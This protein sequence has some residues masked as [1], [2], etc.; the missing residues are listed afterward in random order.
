MI[1][2]IIFYV[3]VRGALKREDDYR[4]EQRCGPQSLIIYCN[5]ILISYSIHS[6][7]DTAYI[8][9]V[10]LDLSYRINFNFKQMLRSKQSEVLCKPIPGNGIYQFYKHAN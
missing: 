5:A 9:I 3:C 1:S 7:S 10:A 8:V 6:G 4:L 2:Y